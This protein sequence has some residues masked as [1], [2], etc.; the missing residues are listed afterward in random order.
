MGIF[1]DTMQEDLK[2]KG[3][4]RSTQNTYLRC[5][6]R[7]VAFHMQP[8]TELGEKEIRAFLM[9][10]LEER[11]VGPANHKTHIAAIKFLYNTTM[12]RPEEVVRIPWPKVPRT[13]PDILS[14]DETMSLLQAVDSI[15][16]RAVLMASYGAGL[17]ITEACSLRVE[18]LDSERGLIHV[19]LGK[20]GRDRYVMLSDRLLACL[21]HYWKS[22]RPEGSFLFPGRKTG[23]HISANAVRK[24]VRKASDKLG[25]TKRVTPHKLRHAFAT[26]LLEDGCDIRVIQILLGHGSIRSTARYTHV[27]A[28]HIGQVKSPL[29]TVGKQRRQKRRRA[30]V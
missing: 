12:G 17:R 29:D 1:Y 15:M 19:R 18:D 24:A 26:H 20:G 3:Y 6:R 25:I 27:S 14:R 11:K 10:L 22:V 4:A 23:T 7:L 21:R 8:P 9:H 28:K 13:L 16:H 30:S 5:A 2:L